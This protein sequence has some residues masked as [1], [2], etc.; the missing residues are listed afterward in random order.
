MEALCARRI[1]VVFHPAVTARGAMPTQQNAV[2]GC[3][4]AALRA[5]L[6]V[7]DGQA[8]RTPTAA[9]TQ[10]LRAFINQFA[11]LPFIHRLAGILLRISH[12]TQRIGW[13]GLP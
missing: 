5:L 9:F 4:Q 12:S 2:I 10:L 11:A 3:P 6:A 8:A 1:R 13:A 7:V